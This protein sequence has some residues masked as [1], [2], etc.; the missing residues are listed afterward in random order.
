MSENNSPEIDAKV[1]AAITAVLAICGYSQPEGYRIA[2]IRP[3][4]ASWRRAGIEDSII[5]RSQVRNR[6]LE[7]RLGG[8]R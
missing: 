8:Y 2:G 1:L 5:A 7:L 4:S 3:V 6:G